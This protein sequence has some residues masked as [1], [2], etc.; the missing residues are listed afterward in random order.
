MSDALSSV[1]LP[2]SA[3]AEALVAKPPVRPLD[4]RDM[5][6]T[7]PDELDKVFKDYEAVYMSQMLSHMMSGIEVDPTFGGGPGEEMMRSLLVNEY[8]KSMSENG[9]FGLADAMKKQ[10]L[11]QQEAAHQATQGVEPEAAMNPVEIKE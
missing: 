3:S 2:P 11:Q 6:G 9:G 1:A 5:R 4:A 8:G 7:K 10:L